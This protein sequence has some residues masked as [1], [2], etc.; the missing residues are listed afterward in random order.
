MDGLQVG[1]Y[2]VRGALRK[3]AA[4]LHLVTAG[5]T[6]QLL[7]SSWVPAAGITVALASNQAI[8]LP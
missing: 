1:R 6:V 4:T 3:G 7:V 8:S 5:V 2:T